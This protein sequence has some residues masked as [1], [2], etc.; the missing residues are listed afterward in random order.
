MKF[1]LGLIA[2]VGIWGLGS[3]A[4]SQCSAKLCANANVKLLYFKSNG[5]ILIELDADTSPLNCTRVS[6]IYVTLTYENGNKEEI[7]ATLL[8][9]Q[10]ASKPIAR[11]RIIENSSEC[12]ISY[13]YQTEHQ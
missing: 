8:A 9:A 12:E 1:R 4:A 6:D 7:F 3:V 13:V 5:D 11:V 10:S 2:C